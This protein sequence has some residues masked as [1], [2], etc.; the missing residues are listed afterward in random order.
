MLSYTTY[1]THKRIVDSELTFRRKELK[2]VQNKIASKKSV[3]EARIEKLK[4]NIQ[5]IKDQY[6]A[7]LDTFT[8]TNT[9]LK[10]V[11]SKISKIKKRFG[12]RVAHRKL[13]IKILSMTKHQSTRM[14]KRLLRKCKRKRRG[15]K[16][17]LRRV[18]NVKQVVKRNLSVFQGKKPEPIIMKS[19]PRAALK[20]FKTIKVKKYKKRHV[21]ATDLTPKKKRHGLFNNIK[22]KKEDDLSNYNP[23]VKQ[24]ETETPQPKKKYSSLF[25]KYKKKNDSLFNSF[26][27]KKKKSSLFGSFK[28]KKKK[29]SLFG[30][31][32]PKKRR[33]QS[34]L[35][36]S[37]KQK[38]KTRSSQPTYRPR[39]QSSLFGKFKRST[40]TSSPSSTVTKRSSLFGGF[41][42]KR[43]RR[44]IT[45]HKLITETKLVNGPDQVTYMMG[46]KMLTKAQYLKMKAKGA[47]I[48][49]EVHHQVIKPKVPKAKEEIM[50]NIDG[51]LVPESEYKK[52]QA[53]GE[54]DD[55]DLY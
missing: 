47:K 54:F 15:L 17:T 6:E 30:S 18:F 38:K 42:K 40:H 20:M 55:V 21:Y 45:K 14:L 43:R 23:V 37:F 1:S 2:K 9:E 46:G 49:E 22:K 8:T 4:K 7:K 39:K 5:L 48:K 11:V 50:Y 33:H 41:K 32:K 34:S 16:M 28:P 10:G 31:F 35:F 29:S 19:L 3:M 26:K 53:N 13:K 27:H 51:K 44:H 25:S 36:G 52:M 12:Y 24:K